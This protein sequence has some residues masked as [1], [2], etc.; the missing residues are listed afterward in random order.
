M[1]DTRIGPQGQ[2]PRAKPPLSIPSKRSATNKIIRRFHR[3][4][5]IGSIDDWLAAVSD[6][7]PVATPLCGVF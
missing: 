4:P 5:Q 2:L 3:F 7:D 1:L 6:R